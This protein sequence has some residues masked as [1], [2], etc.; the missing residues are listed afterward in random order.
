MLCGYK[1]FTF[2]AFKKCKSSKISGISKFDV[3]CFLDEM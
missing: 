3:L 1:K 2:S